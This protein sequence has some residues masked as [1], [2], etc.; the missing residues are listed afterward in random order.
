MSTLF[1]SS[2]TFDA[3]YHLLNAE[4]EVEKDRLTERWRN[5][6]LEELNFMGIVVSPDSFRRP[7][8][9]L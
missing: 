6:K 8:I 2:T 9:K 5:S 7:N 4:D 1:S 3:I